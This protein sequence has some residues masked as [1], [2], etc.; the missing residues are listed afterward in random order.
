VVGAVQHGR[1]CKDSRRRQLWR[2]AG[3][4]VNRD[5]EGF[6]LQST[7][8]RSTIGPFIMGVALLLSTN[9]VDAS[10]QMRSRKRRRVEYRI[11]AKAASG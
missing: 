8:L 6:F 4:P 7:V 5:S 10:H 2:A 1:P 3:A 9:W 11:N